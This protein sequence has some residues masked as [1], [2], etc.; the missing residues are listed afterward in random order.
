MVG[1]FFRLL[2]TRNFIGGNG[3]VCTGNVVLV[4]RYFKAILARCGNKVTSS[5]HLEGL[6]FPR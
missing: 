3:F 4:V 5:K 6:T 1:A 2:Q